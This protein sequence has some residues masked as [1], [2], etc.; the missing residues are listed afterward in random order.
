MIRGTTPTHIFNLPFAASTISALSVTY[1]QD[2]ETL[3]KKQKADCTLDGNAVIVKL[4]QEESLKFTARDSVEVQLKVK[5]A[6]GDVIA[7]TVKSI[8]VK[9]ILDEEVL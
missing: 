1:K 5:D 4:T 2:G 3:L 9:R 7:H 8:P 6:S